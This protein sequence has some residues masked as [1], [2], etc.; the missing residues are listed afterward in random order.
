MQPQVYGERPE[1]STHQAAQRFSGGRVNDL[2]LGVLGG[3]K[4]FA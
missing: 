3:S 4:K 1:S 2:K